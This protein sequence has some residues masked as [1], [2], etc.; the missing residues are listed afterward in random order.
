MKRFE[1][2]LKDTSN[3]LPEQP[4][5]EYMR[6]FLRR[7]ENTG[8]RIRFL[9]SKE[10]GLL[11]GKLSSGAVVLVQCSDYTYGRCHFELNLHV[12]LRCN[13]SNLKVTRNVSVSFSKTI[14]EKLSY[15]FQNRLK[16]Y[17]VVI[18][19]YLSASLAQSPIDPKI[20]LLF[21]ETIT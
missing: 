9:V 21:F 18:S 1:R 20:Y 16:F 19:L 17:I 3:E 8:S 11:H 5:F 2:I 10:Y 4:Y 12:S 15:D 13:L 14:F 7:A 6:R